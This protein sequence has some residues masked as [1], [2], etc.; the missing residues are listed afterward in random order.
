MPFAHFLYNILKQADI[1]GTRLLSCMMWNRRLAPVPHH[2]I[3][4][5]R[6]EAARVPSERGQRLGESDMREVTVIGFAC[7]K[8][9]GIY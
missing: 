6:G 8:K 3:N 1:T 7:K 4:F 2:I 5:L 9:H